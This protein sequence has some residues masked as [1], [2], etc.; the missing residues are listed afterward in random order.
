[1]SRLF[2]IVKQTRTSQSCFF[3][4]M[5]SQFLWFFGMGIQFV[6][7]QA[8]AALILNLSA[9]QIGLAQAA[10]L[11]PNLLFMLPG[12]VTAERN[13]GRLLLIRLQSAAILPPLALGVMVLTKQIDFNGLLIFCFLM[14]IIS[15]FIVPT[16]DR[17]LSFIVEPSQI[18]R[19]I[20]IATSLQFAGNLFGM[21]LIAIGDQAHLGWFIIA[22]SVLLSLAVFATHRL[23]FDIAPPPKNSGHLMARRRDQI[24]DG[25]K[26]ALNDKDIAPILILLFAMSIF[27]MGTFF[28]FFPLI[29]RD[30]YHGGI[31]DIAII[32]MLFWTGMTCAAF[33]LIKYG[34]IRFLGRMALGAISSGLVVLWLFSFPGNFWWLACLSLIWGCGGGVFTSVSRTII[35]SLAPISHRGRLLSI[36]Q[37]AFMGG[38][39]IGV[40]GFGLLA[41]KVSNIHIAPL[42]PMIFMLIIVIFLSF[43]S[44]ILFIDIKQRKNDSE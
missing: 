15:A 37:L 34:Q 13:E 5:A 33:V 23:D 7:V 27:F 40:V 2:D 32:N 3:W 17:L 31:T 9:T 22:Q 36:Y 19:A 41:D 14:G 1:M 28:V 44:N 24:I 12:G 10:L 18:E 42:I 11:L 43:Y 26:Y 21:A 6:A 35:Q 29:I 39:P 4:Y 38:A 16:R 25:L 8:V 20:P 30:Y